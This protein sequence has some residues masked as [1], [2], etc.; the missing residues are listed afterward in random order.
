[1]AIDA[2]S[3][4]ASAALA[5]DGS[6]LGEV[7][8]AAREVSLLELVDR[9]FHQTGRAKRDL[10]GIVALSG[11]GS[12]TGVRITLST[13]MGLAPANTPHGPRVYTLSTLAALALQ[14]PGKNGIVLAVVDALRGEWFHQRFARSRSGLEALGQ[15]VRENAATVDLSG[16]GSVVAFSEAGVAAN[17]PSLT[18]SAAAPLAGAVAAAAS[19][20]L[21]DG[22]LDTR[23]LPLYLRAPAVT[24]PSRV[25]G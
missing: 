15:P 4:Q 6:L 12:F 24:L 19:A 20:G 3:P 7:W 14:G 9:L 8:A 1:M 13:A 16:I 21:L 23:L 22:Q 11:P 25:S 5:A 18:V 10:G 17:H 2:G